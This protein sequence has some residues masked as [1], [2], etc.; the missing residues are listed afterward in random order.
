MPRAARLAAVALAVAAVVLTTA[1]QPS[2]GWR[3]CRGIESCDAWTAES[4]AAVEG[5]TTQA[6]CTTNCGSHGDAGAGAGG[7]GGLWCRTEPCDSKGDNCA[8]S[9]FDENLR[10]PVRPPRQT[11]DQAR[12]MHAIQERAVRDSAAARAWVLSYF[13]SAKVR[14]N[15]DASLQQHSD[16]ELLVR[17]TPPLCAILYN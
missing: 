16:E 5:C 4:C 17:N 1:D 7:G 10:L 11:A 12:A 8:S 14:Q 3:C 6:T 15:L 2:G 13:G 9:L